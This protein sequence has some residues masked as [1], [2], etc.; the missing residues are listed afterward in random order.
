M[1][2]TGAR[3][4]APSTL[5]DEA[6]TLRLADLPPLAPIRVTCRTR[7]EMGRAWRSE[8]TFVSDENGS[9]DVSATAPTSGSYAGVDR[10]GLFW[11]MVLEMAT[12]GPPF[13]KRTAAPLL[14][15]LDVE[16]DGMVMAS[17]ALERP[18]MADGVTRTEVKHDGLVGVLYEPPGKG[19]H[20]GVIVLLG[21]GGGLSEPRAALLASRGH[22][23]LALAYFAAPGLPASLSEIPL[24]YFERAITWLSQRAG[25][26]GGGVHLFG[27][28]RGGEVAL[29]L[30]ATSASVRS[31]CAWVPSGVVFAGVGSDPSA[32][33]KP[34]WTRHGEAIPFIG[35]HLPL[36]VPGSP[37]AADAIAMTPMFLRLMEDASAVARCEIAVERIPGPVLL[38][39]AEEDAMWPS[40]RLSDM[41]VRRMEERGHGSSH[42]H[43]RNPGAGHLLG[44]PHLP[45]TVH[46]VFQPIARLRF[47]F[48]GEAAS[49]AAASATAWRELLAFL[50]QP[51]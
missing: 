2:S 28:S 38:V 45:S 30:G 3:I 49:N 11:S 42:R 13:V 24:E 19:P 48:G 41:V 4:D 14:Y 32:Y 51:A 12:P 9:L 26:A 44:I 33:E 37:E 36:P 20:P 39:S 1:T 46:E 34:A 18:F 10:M 5:A 40:S 35:A 29:L 22:A 25:V 47:L 16:V 17:A 31:V 50:P 23:A 8:A 7:D 43:L 27:Q 21:S 15:E 6:I